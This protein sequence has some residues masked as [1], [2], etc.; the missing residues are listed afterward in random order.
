M[1][2]WDVSAKPIISIIEFERADIKLNPKYCAALDGTGEKIE[3]E[4]L[5]QSF[6]VH[7]EP[8]VGV[9]IV[10]EYYYFVYGHFTNNPDKNYT[11]LYQI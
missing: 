1:S 7:S 10:G 2:F 8:F 5:K 6:L 11:I 9:D 3:N 4:D